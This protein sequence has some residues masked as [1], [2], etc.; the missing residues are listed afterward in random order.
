MIDTEREEKRYVA[1]M[2]APP[3]RAAAPQA[4]CANA[5]RKGHPAASAACVAPRRGVIGVLQVY[6]F[7]S[8]P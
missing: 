8:Q 4:Q 6:R 5:A 3:R 1:F 7:F 2:P